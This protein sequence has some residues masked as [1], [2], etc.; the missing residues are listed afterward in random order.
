[1]IQDA[2]IRNFEIIGEAT[3]KYLIPYNKTMRISP[4]K[5]LQ[6]CAKI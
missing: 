5:K 2:V 3:K 6:V 4:G 1:M